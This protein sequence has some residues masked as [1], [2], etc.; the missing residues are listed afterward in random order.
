[1][2]LRPRPEVENLQACHHGGLDYNGVR[3]AG[4][5][6]EQVI[7]FSVCAN[8]FPPPPGVREIFRT[9]AIN[10][11]PDSEATELR[12]CLFAKLGVAADNILAGSGAV[13]PLAAVSRTRTGVGSPGASSMMVTDNRLTVSWNGALETGDAAKKTRAVSPRMRDFIRTS[14]YRISNIQYPFSI[15][16]RYSIFNILPNPPGTQRDLV[17]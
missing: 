5:T 15:F 16:N 7:D 10:R 14:A 12:Q 1:M 17:I 8:P 6:P 13:A 2:S 3:V 4:R 11:Y 9:V